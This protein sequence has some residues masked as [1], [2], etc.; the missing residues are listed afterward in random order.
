MEWRGSRVVVSGDYKR[1]PDPPA[2]R[3]S[4]SPAT[5]S[6]PRRPSACRCSA[7]RPPT[8]KSAACGQR[9]AVPRAHPCIGCYS[10]GKTQ[11]LIAL[12]RAAAGTRRSGCMARLVSMCKVYEPWASGSA[13][14][15]RRRWRRRKA[16]WSDRVG[17]ASACR[18]LGAAAGGAGGVHGSGWMRC[19]ARKQGASNCAGDLRP[20]RLGRAERHARRGRGAGDLG[21][22]RHRDR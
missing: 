20:R 8:P 16:G 10:L 6:S 7:I 5:S 15:G 11:R 12:L 19:A 9:G 21:H 18:P 2:T 22:A 17:P 13:I 14:S 3:S 1:R 4:R